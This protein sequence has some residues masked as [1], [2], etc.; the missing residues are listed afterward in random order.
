MQNWGSLYICEYF[1]IHGTTLY[2]RKLGHIL[3]WLIFLV[4]IYSFFF[5][6]LVWISWFSVKSL[7]ICK[8]LNSFSGCS[9]STGNEMNW[10]SQLQRKDASCKTESIRL[11]HRMLVFFRTNVICIK[12][13]LKGS[14]NRT[15][16]STGSN[17]SIQVNRVYCLLKQLA[18]YPHWKKKKRI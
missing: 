7:Q 15:N 6:L 12:S 5:F 11:L 13:G 2:V 8:L 14:R 10:D 9:P 17:L 4:L 3:T 1:N 16:H 18:S